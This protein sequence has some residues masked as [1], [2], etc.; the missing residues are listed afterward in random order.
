[1]VKILTACMNTALAALLWIAPVMLVAYA[2]LD[3]A[4]KIWKAK[5]EH[6]FKTAA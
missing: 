2:A 5:V 3:K 6:N 1:M 4:S